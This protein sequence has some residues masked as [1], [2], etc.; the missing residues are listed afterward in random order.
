MGAGELLRFVFRY[1]LL[2]SAARFASTR[3]PAT[4]IEPVPLLSV[5]PCGGPNLQY[6]RI[7]PDTH[8]GTS[9]PGWQYRSKGDR[10][11][12]ESRKARGARGFRAQ[13]SAPRARLVLAGFCFSQR[14]D[15][16]DSDR[17]CSAW[18]RGGQNRRWLKCLCVVSECLLLAGGLV[19]G[20]AIPRLH[21][22]CTFLMRDVAS[23]VVLLR[24]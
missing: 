15:V 13:R 18:A 6:R 3:R 23:R 20:T 22:F 9:T 14:A 4:H 8:V 7:Y 5:V 12:L 16:S 2:S 19:V 24:S 17:L 1:E 11:I 21:C 10:E